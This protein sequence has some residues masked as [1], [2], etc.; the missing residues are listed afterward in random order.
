MN[1]PH[2]KLIHRR[3]LALP[4]AQALLRALQK[5]DTAREQLRSAA[6]EISGIFQPLLSEIFWDSFDCD[7]RELLI[8]PADAQRLRDAW[9]AFQSEGGATAQD[10]SDW[11]EGRPISRLDTKS[12][13]SKRHLRLIVSRPKQQHVWHGNGGEAA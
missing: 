1:S 9:S 11:L 6:A 8:A 13:P 10:F 3:R 12:G 4:R 2:E 5:A 7:D